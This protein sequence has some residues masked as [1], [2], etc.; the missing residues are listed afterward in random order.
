MFQTH[1]ATLPLL[2]H[3][4][5]LC[6]TCWCCPT[7]RRATKNTGTVFHRLNKGTGGSIILVATTR[8]HLFFV[9]ELGWLDNRKIAVRFPERHESFILSKENNQL[10]GTMNLVFIRQK[11]NVYVFVRFCAGKGTRDNL[12]LRP[13]PTKRNQNAHTAGLLLNRWQSSV[14][15]EIS[16]TFWNLIRKYRVHSSPVIVL[17]LRQFNPV[18]DLLS[19][20]FKTPFNI[21]FPSK[22][23]SP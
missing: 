4:V 23:R 13:G 14:G 7:Q 15:Q 20:L 5:Q 11:D 22:T 12:S 21:V 2:A 8:L 10:F 17:I 9:C 18:Q 3:L 19:Y 6:E 16:R 1:E